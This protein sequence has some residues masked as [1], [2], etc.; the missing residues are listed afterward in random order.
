MTEI[1]S[2][3]VTIGADISNFV[4]G[5]R[6]TNTKL[7]G[8]GQSAGTAIAGLGTGITNLGG[9]MQTLGSNIGDAVAPM[10]DFVTGGIEAASGFEDIMTQLKSF[11]GLADDELTA[12]SDLALKLGADTKFSATDAADAMLN[13]VKAGMSTTEAMTAVEAAMT[14]AAVG[15][16]GVA[17]A[18]SIVSTSLAQFGIDAAYASDVV[19]LL[20]A[21]ANVSSASVQS[22]ADGLANVGPV[23]AAAGLNIMETSAALA[24]MSNAGIQGAE[25]G[26]Q[27]KALLLNFQSDT[28]EDAFDSLGVSLYDAAGNTRDFDTVLDDLAL[29]LADKTPEE[30]ADLMK[31]LAGSYGIT[32][33]N[34]LMAA[35]GIDST[36]EAMTQ[37]PSAASLAEAAM[38]TFSG[39]VDGLSG[40]VETLMITALTPLMENVLTPMVESVTGIVNSITDWAAKNPELA[41]TIGGI[42]LVV[43]ALGIGL[44]VLGS[45]MTVVGGILTALGTGLGLI[46][47]PVG[48]L[49]G[50]VALLVAV[51]N[52]PAIQSGL[53]AWSGVFDMFGTIADAIGA[54]IGLKLNDVAV[55]IRSFFRDIEETINRIQIA[56]A[57]IQMAAGINWDANAAS[58]DA[59]IANMDTIGLAKGIETTLNDQLAA[60][61][62]INLDPSQYTNV[63]YAALASKITDPVLIQEAV[64]AA[65]AE[66]DQAALGVLLPLA[67]ELGIDTQSIVDQFTATITSAT[68]EDYPA[69]VVVDVLMTAGNIDVTGFTTAIT[70]AANSADVPN[71]GGGG[72]NSL[73][74]DVVP[75]LDTGGTIQ[76]EGLAYLHAGEVVLNQG[77]QAAQ[78]NRGPTTVNLSP[79]MSVDYMISELERMGIYLRPGMNGG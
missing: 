23:A 22:I 48:L 62:G 74:A 7:T 44:T 57:D 56:G 42:V 30:Q 39:K 10:F 38:G 45:V 21:A 33:L 2:L 27:L 54:D 1:A 72:G 52:D 29:A 12:V 24:V 49:V 31:A 9:K 47:S 69:T 40:S 71:A 60:G 67:T 4:T 25:A 34:A 17:N 77:Q 11:G 68:A 15:E 53:A 41:S 46:L 55:G 20:A 8:F 63:D 37:A 50:A 61:E 43:G 75:R 3:S 76:S 6:D 28:A 35:G 64:S 65:L 19:D 5:L 36:M 78:G 70:A 26:T 51:V 16:I 73:A 66:G 14:L 58:R 59:A 13:L 32:A 18:A 79:N